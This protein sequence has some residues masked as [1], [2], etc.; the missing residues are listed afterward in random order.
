MQ[1]STLLFC[2]GIYQD[3]IGTYRAATELLIKIFVML[4]V[5]KTSPIDPMQ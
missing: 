1:N 3:A 4:V 5:E 2:L